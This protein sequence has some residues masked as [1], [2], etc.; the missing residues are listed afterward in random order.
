[1]AQGR[2]GSQGPASVPVHLFCPSIRH[3]HVCIQSCFLPSTHPPIIHACVRH[4]S[5]S[6]SALPLVS[7]SCLIPSFHSS[8]CPYISFF[9]SVRPSTPPS[10]RFFLPF[11]HPSICPFSCPFGPSIRPEHDEQSSP[12]C[13][14]VPVQPGK[15]ARLKDLRGDGGLGL[16]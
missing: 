7:L 2:V 13:P 4:P 8:L 9:P 5:F 16:P 1:M 3:V 10:I 15:P 14:R 6:P 11:I 12:C